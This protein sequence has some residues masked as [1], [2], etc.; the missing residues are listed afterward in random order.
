MSFSRQA[1][2]RADNVLAAYRRQAEELRIKRTDEIYRKIPQ[3][4]KIDDETVS[5]GAKMTKAALDGAEDIERII[6][7]T[8]VQLSALKETKSA[9]LK[10]NG[11]TENYMSDI[12]RCPICRD[13]GFTDGKPCVCR[14]KIM[15]EYDLSSLNLDDSN[16]F[17]NFR[18]D[19]YSDVLDEH[20]KR[21]PRSQMKDVFEYCKN[22]A[23]TF[24]LSSDNIMMYGK[25][26]LGKTFLCSCIALSLAEKGYS[27]VFQS[28]YNIFEIIS[29]NK[30]NYKTDYSEDIERL[31]GCDLL[32]MDDL[33][34]E[35]LTEYT[36]T[37][38]FD[39]I[40]RRLVSKKPTII[41]FNLAPKDVEARYSDRIM[42]RLLTFTHLL[43]LGDDIR[44][45]SLR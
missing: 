22:Y 17:E 11:Y 36:H 24:S 32:I 16:R 31:Y 4:K 40:E 29:K 13:T 43:F 45:A 28:A 14:K 1:A 38:L 3:I 39:I 10:E 18:L 8:T 26:G 33:G 42:S 41:N 23:E 15:S 6:E 2:E 37:A 5:L 21:S 44:A 27:V 34:T 19:F 25:V 20:Y 12:Y 7:N 30:F 9:L 35:F